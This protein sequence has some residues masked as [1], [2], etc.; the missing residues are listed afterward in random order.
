MENDKVFVPSRFENIINNY[1][2]Y[3]TIFVKPKKDIKSMLGTIEKM[4][5]QRGGALSIL[6]GKTG[7]GKTTMI[8]AL[9]F[10]EP[11]IFN[12]VISIPENIGFK[13]I[14]D[15]MKEKIGESTHQIKIVLLDGR[16]I[17]DDETGLT[18]FLTRLNQF[19]RRRNDVLVCWPVNNEEWYDKLVK[20]GREIGGKN[21]IPSQALI[22]VQGP[23][24][25]KW[26]QALQNLLVFMDK[27]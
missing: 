19:L 2:D 8:H 9:P 7:V 14:I 5:T 16:E 11:Q 23:S 24:R 26:K 22:E 12:K 13:D 4:R 18:N 17:I 15:I 6:K 25:E 3:S 27:T 10:Y 20:N 1:D 21:F